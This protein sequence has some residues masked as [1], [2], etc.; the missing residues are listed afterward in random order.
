MECLDCA[1]TTKIS[2]NWKRHLTSKKHLAITGH[3]CRCG[4]AYATERSLRRHEKTCATP[5][6]E[7]V[8]LQLAKGQADRD[9]RLAQEQAARDARHA[10]EIERLLSEL[11]ARPATVLNMNNNTNCSFNLALFLN[12]QCKNAPTIEQFI[13]NI[14]IR[15]D[16]SLEIG[17]YILDNLAKCAVE[18]RPIH[19]TDAKR[20]KLAV[21]RGDHGWEQDRAKTDPLIAHNINMLRCRFIEHLS[22]VWCVENPKCTEDGPVCDEYVR[23]YAMTCKDV[24]E[25]FHRHLAKATLIPKED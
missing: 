22:E 13:G 6:L 10:A 25:K 4:N 9:A 5:S 1:F 19:C 24:D 23:L 2:S 20:G 15:M 17:Q 18:D 11:A 12:E 16:S 14:P 7:A 8:V 21:K 3:A